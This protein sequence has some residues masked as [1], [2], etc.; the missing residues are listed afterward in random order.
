MVKVR[1]FTLGK[2][3][4]LPLGWTL[5]PP[6]LRPNGT[7][8]SKFLSLHNAITVFSARPN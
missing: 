8:L 4:I 2:F 7:L 5:V 6:G 1:N 3:W